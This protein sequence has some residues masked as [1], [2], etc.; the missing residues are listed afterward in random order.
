MYTGFNSCDWRIF[1]RSATRTLAHLP[2]PDSFDSHE[3]WVDAVATRTDADDPL[4]R[5][6]VAEL[7]QHQSPST[8]DSTARSGTQHPAYAVCQ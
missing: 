3:E 4:V 5:A 2:L 6:L 1:G 7:L 8:D